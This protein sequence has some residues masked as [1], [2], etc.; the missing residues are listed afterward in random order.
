MEGQKNIV[1]CIT[2]QNRNS[3]AAA[4][5]AAGSAMERNVRNIDAPS[6]RAASISSNGNAEERYC[7]IQNTPKGHSMAGMITACSLPTH[8]RSVIRRSEEHT[9]ELQSRGHLVC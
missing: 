1:H 7:V 9:S 2:N 4:G 5:A 8:P 3:M 6:T